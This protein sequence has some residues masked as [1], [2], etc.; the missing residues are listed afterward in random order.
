MTR[1]LV[2]VPQVGGADGA[3]EVGR[4]IAGALERQVGVSLQSLDV[5]S[6]A[7]DVRPAALP[8][9][10]GFRT[11]RSSRMAFASY[12]V[13][14]TAVNRDTLVV[15][16]H[17]HLL[18]VTLPLIRRGARIVP[19]L[20][21]IEAW[22]PLRRLERAALRRAWRILAISQHTID[23][24][25]AAN[26]AVAGLP[27]E[28][29]H[30]ASR[31]VPSPAPGRVPGRFA[32]IVG[33][34]AASER[35]KGHDVLLE[36]WARVRTAVP[37]ARL[38]VAG[39]GDDEPR[40]RARVRALEL[41]GAVEFEGVV[42]DAR[43]AALYRDAAMFVMPSRDEG[44]GLVYLEA[45]RA[46]TPCIAAPG[47]AAE[48]IEHGVSGL[49]LDPADRDALVAAIVRLFTDGPARDALGRAAARRVAAHY[50]ESAFAARLCGVLDLA[51]ADMAGHRKPQAA[52]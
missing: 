51:G 52:C 26:P 8:A 21:G 34:M 17:A 29:C 50:G 11:A 43:L 41:D 45:M 30:P 5:W 42:N 6:L 3:S 4:Q 18:P 16:L 40:L 2:L 38:V 19:V 49:I 20:L 47:A 13:R 39:G 46:G 7:D 36:I 14:D 22:R 9:R 15:V 25:R 37:D 23:R 10:A 32:L 1:A 48:F 33:R 12:A 35:Y 44:F 31:A 27:V 28:V 24:F